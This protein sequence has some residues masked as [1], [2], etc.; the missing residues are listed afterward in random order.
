MTKNHSVRGA[1]PILATNFKWLLTEQESGAI[2]KTVVGGHHQKS[3]SEASK[4][5]KPPCRIMVI[6]SGFEPDYRSS[7]L[8]RAS[9]SKYISIDL[10]RSLNG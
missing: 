5:M 7:N 1:I 6:T 10:F 4:L 8:R 3:S 9:I 2:C